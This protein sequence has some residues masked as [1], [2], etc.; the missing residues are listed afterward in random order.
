MATYE[1]LARPEDVRRY[2]A[3]QQQTGATD[4][5]GTAGGIPI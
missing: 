2:R 4:S 5:L 3:L 1:L